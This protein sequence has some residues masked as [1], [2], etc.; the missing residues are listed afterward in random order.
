MTSNGIDQLLFRHGR[1]YDISRGR[2]PSNAGVQTMLDFLTFEDDE[3]F[4]FFVDKT[5]ME[6]VIVTDDDTAQRLFHR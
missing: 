4:N 5:Q 1:R 3:V 6:K 2:I